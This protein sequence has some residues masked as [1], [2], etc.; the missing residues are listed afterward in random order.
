MIPPR[1][2]S[3]G[4]ALVIVLLAISLLSAMAA[5]LTLSSALARYVA[6]NYD[7]AL[8]L[9]NAAESALELAAR[10]LAG[11]SIDA[12]LAGAQA[13]S[14]TDGAA[15]PRTLAAGFGIDLATL[16]NQLTC[17]R[18]EACSDAQVAQPA[19]DRPWGANNPRWRLF[20]HRW[21]SPPASIA[22]RPPA[23]YVVV[24]VGDDAGEA[25]GDALHDGAGPAHEG[26]YVL[27]AR[28][29][30]FGPRGARYA[31]EADVARL[32]TEGADGPVCTPGMHVQSWRAVS[33]VP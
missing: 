8:A 6:A 3:R 28:A 18:H 23:I 20:V 29:E 7:E 33:T 32:C 26:R 19:S 17:G 30:A 27:R 15:G 5:G 13:S 12:V 11:A 1:P 21:L 22:R 24:W 31:L 2:S 4:V 14:H 25:D 9:Q 10:D 16:T